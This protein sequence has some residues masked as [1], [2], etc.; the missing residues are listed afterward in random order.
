MVIVGLTG[1]ISTGKSTVSAQLKELGAVIV[2][3]DIIAKEVVLKGKPAWKK[4]VGEFGEEIL[5]GDGEL[6]R[7]KLGE[8]IFNDE[9]KRKTLNGITHPAV[10]MEMAK[11][12]LGAVFTLKP[13]IVLDVPLLFESGKLLFLCSHVIT[14]ACD[15][16]I[17]ISRLMARNDLSKEEAEARI[18]SQMSLTE[19]CELS[20]T[21]IENNG[22]RGELRQ[23]VNQVFQEIYPQWT[24]L[25]TGL[26]VFIVALGAFWFF[27]RT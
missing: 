12:I 5:Q 21:V 10:F 24:V 8:I 20:D 2:D 15:E 9:V 26:P 1:G 4:I 6:N 14:V 23:V 3:A 22:T 18:N 11:Q 25:G 17:E 16:N 27:A 13:L 19:K 7:A